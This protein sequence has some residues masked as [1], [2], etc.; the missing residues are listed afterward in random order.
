M[1]MKQIWIWSSFSSFL[2]KHH[3]LFSQFSREG[4]LHDFRSFVTKMLVHTPV[5]CLQVY[6]RYAA[7]THQKRDCWVKG[8]HNCNFDRHYLTGYVIPVSRDG[9]ACVP[10]PT[11]TVSCHINAGLRGEICFLSVALTC[12]PLMTV[13]KHLFM[14]LRTIS[15]SFIL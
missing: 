8:K 13:L 12:I 2:L 7:S 6:L 3:S 15:I 10:Q 4:P 14:W 11:H 5:L 9:S 1:Q